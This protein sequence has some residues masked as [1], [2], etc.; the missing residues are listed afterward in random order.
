MSRHKLPLQSTDPHY[1][2]NSRGPF[3]RRLQIT[4]KMSY[5]SVLTRLTAACLTTQYQLQ[6]LLRA[7]D[8][9]TLSDKH[10]RPSVR[11]YLPDIP[12]IRCK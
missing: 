2:A 6:Q 5:L 7:P 1:R 11:V 12:K 4:L 3:C 8:E 10:I 9:V